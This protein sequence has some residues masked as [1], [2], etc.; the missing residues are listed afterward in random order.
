MGVCMCVCVCEY[1]CLFMALSLLLAIFERAGRT[2][3]FPV[4]TSAPAIDRSQGKSHIHFKEHQSALPTQQ[5]QVGRRLGIWNMAI[6]GEGQIFPNLHTRCGYWPWR[7]GLT[8][9]LLFFLLRSE[10]RHR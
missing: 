2:T 10:T 1:I 4:R 5:F 7:P 3:H 8:R 9:Q 6:S